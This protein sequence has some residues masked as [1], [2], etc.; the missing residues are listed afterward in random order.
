MITVGIAGQWELNIGLTYKE[1]DIPDNEL[2]KITPDRLD[3]FY[4]IEEIGNTLPFFRISFRTTDK[5]KK[6][7]NENSCLKL[8][9][10][11][12][13]STKKVIDTKMAILMKDCQDTGDGL[14]SYTAEGLYVGD[15]SALV[16]YQTPY[17]KQVGP[18][19]GTDCLEKCAEVFFK[20]VSNEAT[21][22]GRMPWYQQNETYKKFLDNVIK[23]SYIEG[24]FVTVGITMNGEYRIVDT[25]KTCSGEEQWTIGKGGGGKDLPLITFPK[26]TSQSGVQNALGGYGLELPIISAEYGVRTNYHPTINLGLTGKDHPETSTNAAS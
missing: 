7:W 17:I 9:M 20:K 13:K 5:W 25:V 12:G 14:F 24:S 3:E 8:S 22:K 1:K 23:H 16:M 2:S 21:S 15:K 18:C 26:L 11:M 10:S 6:Y 4:I 19:I